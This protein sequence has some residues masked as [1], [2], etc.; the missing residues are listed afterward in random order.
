MKR[1]MMVATALTLAT[2]LTSQTVDAEETKRK[3]HSLSQLIDQDY[4]KKINIKEKSFYEFDST[5]KG[6]YFTNNE[7]AKDRLL[8]YN[9]Q[10]H[11]LRTI[12][13]TK[14]KDDS[15]I[16]DVSANEKWVTW[17][18]TGDEVEET[19]VIY[20]M[21]TATHQVKLLTPKAQRKNY[22]HDL[23]LSGHYIAYQTYNQH[24][25]QF[26]VILQDLISQKRKVIMASKDYRSQLR[27]Q[28]GKLIL[29]VISRHHSKIHVYSINNHQLKT[30]RLPN[31]RVHEAT[32]VGKK[33][34]YVATTTSDTTETQRVML[35]NPQSKSVVKFP[36]KMN[37]ISS[38]VVGPKNQVYL[39]RNHGFYTPFAISASGQISE[40]TPLMAEQLKIHNRLYV[41]R[42]ASASGSLTVMTKR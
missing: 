15:L 16:K 31:V 21:N 14:V 12:Y 29:N 30:Y 3:A 22:K 18:D 33:L 38:I 37:M 26:E 27:V 11:K 23:V 5:K 17:V 2:V 41:Y 1:I 9:R 4:G 6:V 8:E 25:H 35:Y 28:D 39:Q 7:D 20:A 24:A 13:T 34:L 40:K 42:K 10:T 19:S 32:M 36:K